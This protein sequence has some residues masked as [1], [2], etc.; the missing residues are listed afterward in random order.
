MYIYRMTKKTV[1][2]EDTPGAEMCRSCRCIA[3]YFIPTKRTGWTMDYC[4]RRCADDDA[5]DW[6]DTERDKWAAYYEL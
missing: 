5:R 4:S 3:G 2:T 6:A 1:V